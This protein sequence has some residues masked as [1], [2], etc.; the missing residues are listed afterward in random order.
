M[1]LFSHLLCYVLVTAVC[2]S[3]IVIGWLSDAQATCLLIA[4]MVGSLYGDRYCSLLS[5]GISVIAFDLF[6]L[7]PRNHLSISPAAYP[8][9]AAFTSAA[10]L[11]RFL[12]RSREE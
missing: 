10:F 12:I 6:F 4:V 9:F 11:I 8:R 7:P 5:V 2:C 3:A 1:K